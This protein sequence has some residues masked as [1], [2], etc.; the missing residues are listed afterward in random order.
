MTKAKI[1]YVEDD[2]T[3]SFVTRDNLES[4]GYAIDFLRRWRAGI[5]TL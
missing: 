1:L 5:E 3:L 2:Q 4:H